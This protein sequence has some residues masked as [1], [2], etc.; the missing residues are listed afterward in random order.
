[1]KIFRRSLGALVPVQ[2]FPMS[3]D[4]W[5]ARSKVG[6]ISIPSIGIIDFT[7]LDELMISIRR[8][9]GIFIISSSTS[10]ERSPCHAF[11]ARPSPLLSW[12]P[13]VCEWAH[14]P[15]LACKDS[16][17]VCKLQGRII[18]DMK[19]QF[20]DIGDERY[21]RIGFEN[22]YSC[23]MTS[24]CHPANVWHPTTLSQ[25]TYLTL[26]TV[27]VT[28]TPWMASWEFM[29]S[30]SIFI[31]CLWGSKSSNIIEYSVTFIGNSFDEK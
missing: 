17:G 4:T 13:H 28:F 3:E 23:S 29:H 25:S 5:L 15:W 22:Y 24:S 9:L 10:H 27:I 21:L 7:S 6:D 16:S 20:W 1:M 19:I 26:H 14:L 11:V 30:R 12:A 8:I 31:Q 2:S 18:I